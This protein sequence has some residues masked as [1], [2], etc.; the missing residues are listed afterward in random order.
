MSARTSTD[1]EPVFVSLKTGAARLD[2]SVDHLRDKIAEGELPAFRIGKGRGLI[3]VRV[4]DLDALA[5]RI[6]TAGGAS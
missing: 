2:V 6:P 4:A 5:R 1:T 3:R